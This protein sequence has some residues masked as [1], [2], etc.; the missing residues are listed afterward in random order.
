VE[1]LPDRI[2][3]TTFRWAG[4]T[5]TDW[6]TGLK[7]WDIVGQADNNHTFPHNVAGEK[8]TDSVILDTLPPGSKG[9]PKLTKQDVSIQDMTITAS[10]GKTFTLDKN[11]TVNGKFS[12]QSG[13]VSGSGTLTVAGSGGEMFI[14]VAGQ[15]VTSI[16]Y[17]NAKLVVAPTGDL[18]IASTDDI[19]NTQFVAYK[20]STVTVERKDEKTFGKLTIN[21][22]FNGGLRL[23]DSTINNDGELDLLNSAVIQVTGTGTINNNIGG[24]VVAGGI[25]GQ[26]TDTKIFATLNNFSSPDQTAKGKTGVEVQGN[27]TLTL[28]RGGSSVG[29]WFIA[30]TGKLIFDSATE[31][32]TYKWRKGTVFAAPTL[33]VGN[34]QIGSG[35]LGA[36]VDIAGSTIKFKNVVLT[37]AKGQKIDGQK[38]ELVFDDGGFS[39]NAGNIIGTKI[40]LN[41]SDFAAVGDRTLEDGQLAVNASSTAQV[42]KGKLTLKNSTITNSA[43]FLFTDNSSVVGARTTANGFTNAATGQL[44]KLGNVV[45]T[46]D[47]A[48]TNQGKVD[49]LNGTLKVPN[50]TQ[51]FQAAQTILDGGN[52]DV[53][54]G[55]LDLKSGFLQ[56]AADG[57]GTVIGNVDN[58][59]GT[60]DPGGR[61]FTNNA[62]FAGKIIVM[63]DYTQGKNGSLAIQIFGP[64]NNQAQKQ[65]QLE[66]SGKLELAGTLELKSFDDPSG[67]PLVLVNNT[68][69]QPRKGTFANFTDGQMVTIGNNKPLD[70]K[71]TYMFGPNKNSVALIV[72][73]GQ[74]KID[75]NTTTVA[76]INPSIYGQSITFTATVTPTSGN[77]TPTGT[78]QFQVDGANFG[79]P[80]TLV[81]GTATSNTTSS[82]SV[83]SGTGHSIMAVYSGDT[84]FTGS[85]ASLTQTVN[86][87]GTTTTLV[88]STNPSVFGQSVTYTA[89]VSP[90]APGAGTPTGTVDFYVD[91]S[92][93]ATV[94]ISSGSASFSTSSL[95]VTSGTGHSIMAVYSG[96][97]NF[98]GSSDSLTQTVNQ[99][100]TTTTV[101]GSPNP[102]IYGQSVTFTATVTPASGNGTPTGTIQFQVDGANFGAPVPLVNGT[103]T[104]NSTSSLDAGSHAVAAVYSGDATYLT[105]TGNGMQSVSPAATRIS[106]SGSPNPANQ[107]DTIFFQIQIAT[108]TNVPPQG[109]TLMVTDSFNGG[110]ATTLFTVALG[111]PL[112]QTTLAAGTHVLIVTY[113]GSNNFLGSTSPQFTETINPSGITSAAAALSSTSV[114]AGKSVSPDMVNWSVLGLAVDAAQHRRDALDAF[115]RQF[116]VP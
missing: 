71:F 80:V 61:D 91:G 14:A 113:S 94:G 90:V 76:S 3:P 101:T 57:T 55:K 84:N 82:L 105:S 27:S 99:A 44:L 52:I 116:A 19:K 73:K 51:T 107:G 13:T 85:S 75:T 45:S 100:G 97:T 72:V 11:L 15:N 106:I 89:T 64:A 65:D 88:S 6:N 21:N 23:N 25:L 28:E 59:G 54:G 1:C 37:F 81:N 95:S 78:I 41:G 2:L 92:K 12:Q 86:Q 48:F 26:K 112:P 114:K 7:N 33:E 42:I 79:A 8:T 68:G 83:T 4:L 22:G 66:V 96:D 38:S 36:N 103:A 98:T 60:M 111:D 24:R 43:K 16:V 32:Q 46:I 110:P 77:G 63:G 39:W 109:G 50:F 87:A 67:S 74:G 31:T 47:V 70:Y 34:V 58:S 18:T 108:Q 17:E 56:T 104:S 9:A 35:A 5:N 62:L 30:N 53:T 102:S 93:Q 29:S 69:K 49:I 20:N 40:T 115:F 10:F